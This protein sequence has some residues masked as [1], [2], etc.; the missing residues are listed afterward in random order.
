[1]W[2]P[3]APPRRKAGPD[4]VVVVDED[5]G[6]SH[7]IEGD[8][9]EPEER[10]YPYREKRQNGQHPGCEVAVGGERGEAGGQIGA[11]DAGKDKDEPEE[12]KAV[13]RSDDAVCFEPVHRPE[14][15]QNVSA[16]TKQP[17]DIA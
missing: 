2:R 12:A 16:E 10:T 1:M 15:G 17:R 4:G 5:V 6:R 11:D 13:Q 7:E 3:T 8:D 9:E 14:P